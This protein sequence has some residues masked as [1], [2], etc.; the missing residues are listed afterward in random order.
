ML[1]VS[2][3][4]TFCLLLH[5][6]DVFIKIVFKSLIH[7]EL[8]LYRAWD[9]DWGLFVVAAYGCSLAF[10]EMALFPPLSC[11]LHLC[12]KSVGHIRCVYFWVFYSVPFISVCHS[13]NTTVLIIA[14]VSLEIRFTYSS[15]FIFIF[16]FIFSDTRPRSVT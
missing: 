6:E 16:L 2:R 1:S 15:Y 10:V 14:R 3:L 9:C 12:Q 4:R 8:V 7:F 5:S 13:V 11:F